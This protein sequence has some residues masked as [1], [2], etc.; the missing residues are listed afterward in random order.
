MSN[1]IQT[2]KTEQKVRK[3]NLLKCFLKGLDYGWLLHFV[4]NHVSYASLF[5][6]NLEK[7]LLNDK[8][9]A[10]AKQIYLQSII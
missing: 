1:C 5:A 7:L 4:Y 9:T 8:I 2:M 10:C 3:P 6:M